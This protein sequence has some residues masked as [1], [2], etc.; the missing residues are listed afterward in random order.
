MLR[1]FFVGMFILIL[2]L[3]AAAQTPGGN[4]TGTVRDQQ[5]EAVPGSE[6]TLQ[7]S[8][9]TFRFTTDTGGAFRFREL[10]PGPYQLTAALT[11]FRPATREVI[12]AV[13]GTVDAP[14]VLRVAAVTESVIVSAPAPILDA[15]AT[16]TSTTFSR[17]ELA[18]IP[19]SRDPF[20][21]MRSV[22]GVL[23]D[24]VNIGGNETGQAVQLRLEGHASAGHGLDRSTAS[25]SPTWPPTGASPTYFNFD[26]FEEIQVSTAGQDIAQPTGGIGINFV[27][28]RGTNQFHGGVRGYFANDALESSNVPDELSGDGVTPDTADHNKQISDY[29]V[30]IGGPIMRDNAWFYARIRSRTSSWFAAPARW[31]IARS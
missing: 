25:S 23:I 4:V 16:G 18:K 8:D 13:G 9:A 19:T 5:G 26:N 1:Q 31:S 7:G 11:G 20:A 22:P 27:I 2:A 28:K 29:G 21:L 15:T 3:P 12:V 17:D 30:D 6:V 24:R 10:P 14:L